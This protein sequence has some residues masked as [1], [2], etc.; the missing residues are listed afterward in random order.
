MEKTLVFFSDIR[1]TFDRYNIS[2]QD[3]LNNVGMFFRNLNILKDKFEANNIIFSFI[4]NDNSEFVYEYHKLILPY[5][6]NNDIH[7]RYHLCEDGKLFNN[8]YV[9]KSK[10]DL[11]AIKMFN[12]L[13][14]IICTEEIVGLIYADDEAF[15]HEILSDFLNFEKYQIFDFPIYSIKVDNKYNSGIVNLNSQLKDLI[16]NNKTKCIKKH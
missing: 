12:F 13:N 4:S 10:N 15:Y 7:I 6:Y 1:G 9:I 3:Y 5:I 2:I 8:K 16:V 11:K 14:E